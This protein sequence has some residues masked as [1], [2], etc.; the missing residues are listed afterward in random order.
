VVG[1]VG[2]LQL[3]VVLG[4]HVVDGAPGVIQ[5]RKPRSPRPPTKTGSKERTVDAADQDVGV[6]LAIA[7]ALLEMTEV[8]SWR[9][10]GE[11]EGVNLRQFPKGEGQGQEEAKRRTVVLV[12]EGTGPTIRRARC[13]TILI[14]PSPS[15]RRPTSSFRK[16][17]DM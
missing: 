14:E 5:R 6:V 1:I 10:E 4:A 13:P 16:P 15:R 3:V 17:F 2:R 9:R 12:G 7:S 11:E 8:E